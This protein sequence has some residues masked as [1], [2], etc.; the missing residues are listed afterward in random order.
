M[1]KDNSFLKVFLCQQGN[2]E[3]YGTFS[4]KSIEYEKQSSY[5]YDPIIEKNL[6]NIYDDYL[7]CIEGEKEI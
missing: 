7:K 4:L 6:F 1:T 5:E 2:K 3:L